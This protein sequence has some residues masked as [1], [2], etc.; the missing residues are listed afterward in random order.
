MMQ[1][2][3]LAVG[4]E[5][6]MDPTQSASAKFHGTTYIVQKV[7]P[8]NV[9]LQDEDGNRVNA[10]PFYLAPGRAN[11]NDLGPCPEPAVYFQNGTVVRLRNK[12]ELFVVT[13]QTA[14]GYRIFPLGGSMRYYTGVASSALTEVPL[15]ELPAAIA[16]V[17]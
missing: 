11:P 3:D 6:H 8:K 9:K 5:V 1:I 7:N 13:G 2:T 14:K 10:S 16:K 4:M 12:A 17:A 15:A